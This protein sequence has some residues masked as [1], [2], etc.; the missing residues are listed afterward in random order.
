MG[1]NRLYV[2]FSWDHHGSPFESLSKLGVLRNLRPFDYRV[3]VFE[4]LNNSMMSTTNLAHN[5]AHVLCDFDPK[6]EF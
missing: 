1:T 4:M 6:P 3:A 2:F 5:V